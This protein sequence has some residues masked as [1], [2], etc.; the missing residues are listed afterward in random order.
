MLTLNRHLQDFIQLINEENGTYRKGYI[1]IRLTIIGSWFCLHFGRFKH[2][3]E[4]TFFL[5]MA[6]SGYISHEGYNPIIT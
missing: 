1:F 5:F 2:Y 3:Q 6:K 4:H